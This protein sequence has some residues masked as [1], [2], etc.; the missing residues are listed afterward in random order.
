MTEDLNNSSQHKFSLERGG[1]HK[2]PPLDEEVIDSCRE[3]ESVF[4]KDVV[5]EKKN[6][7]TGAMLLS[8]VPISGELLQDLAIL[9]PG[10][11]PKLTNL[12]QHKYVC[13]N[14]IV[15]VFMT[16]M[17]GKQEMPIPW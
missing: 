6:A 14:V 1:G 9:L 10:Q 13:K 2:A 15:A 17:E 3:R 7:N 8:N 11:F 16:A 12:G 4:F 5:S